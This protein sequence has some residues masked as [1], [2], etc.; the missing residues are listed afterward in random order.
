M[1]EAINTAYECGGFSCFGS[2]CMSSFASNPLASQAGRAVLAVF[3]GGADASA[4]AVVASAFA[5]ASAGAEFASVASRVL[6][7]RTRSSSPGTS[8]ACEGGNRQNVER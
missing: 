5:A 2:A 7:L 8:C 3:M 1:E 4:A 6:L